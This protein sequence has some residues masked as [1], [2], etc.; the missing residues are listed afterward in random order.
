MSHRT[1]IIIELFDHEKNIT[2]CSI[3]FA[4]TVILLSLIQNF[5]MHLTGNSFLYLSQITIHVNRRWDKKKLQ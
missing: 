5:S 1:Q 3:V 4:Y 2:K